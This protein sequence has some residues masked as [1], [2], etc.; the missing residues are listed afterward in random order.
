MKKYFIFLLGLLGGVTLCILLYEYGLEFIVNYFDDSIVTYIL[1]SLILL[2]AALA[3]FFAVDKSITKLEDSLLVEPEIDFNK[4]IKERKWNSINL[5]IK[6]NQKKVLAM[7]SRFSIMNWTFRAIGLIIVG[8]VG[9]LGSVLLHNQNELIKKQNI[10]LDQQT[11]LQEAERRSSLVFLFSNIMDA[12]NVEISNDYNQNNIRD[13]S[14]Q[15]TGRIIA[16]ANRLKPYYFMQGDSLIESQISPERGQLLVTLIE[17]HL[18]DSTFSQIKQRSN[19]SFSDLNQAN[20]S[21]VDLSG[22]NLKNSNMVGA[23]L[24][25]A[26]L[27]GSDFTDSDLSG[28]NF[29]NAKILETIFDDA[30][31]YR[32]NFRKA[33]G[34]TPVFSNSN[35]TRSNLQ[36]TKFDIPI[37]DNTILDSVIVDCDFIINLIHQEEEN[38]M[39][40]GINAIL[41][42]Y[43]LDTI[44]SQDYEKYKPRCRFVSKGAKNN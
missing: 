27:Y 13:L 42:T 37:F 39:D 12:I 23:N 21:G 20:L 33:M 3:V 25:G 19:F 30:N 7:Y 29:S 28:A 34:T 18:A 6:K 8:F 4:I 36:D 9:L 40:L 35:L 22:I 14:P 10:R 41:E 26:K 17:S 15:L 38:E 11:Y 32:S 2:S 24:S 43:S 1:I 44:K 31:L 16:L 5:L